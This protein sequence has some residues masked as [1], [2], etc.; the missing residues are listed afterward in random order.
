MRRFAPLTRTLCALSLCA[1]ALA[2]GPASAAKTVPA[3]TVHPVVGKIQ[4]F[5]G[6]YEST[7]RTAECLAL[8]AKLVTKRTAMKAASEWRDVSGSDAYKVFEES[9]EALKTAN[10]HEAVVGAEKDACKAISDKLVT[11]AGALG[12]TTQ[13]KALIKSKSWTGLFAD[14]AKAEKL[15]CIKPT[16]KPVAAE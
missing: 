11:A 4:Y 6:Y 14:F 5:E 9:H 13:Y 15:G 8:Q 1:S 3:V 16:Q 7:K 12:E 2:A 10:C